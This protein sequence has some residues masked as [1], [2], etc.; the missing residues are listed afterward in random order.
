MNFIAHRGL[1]ARNS[2]ENTLEAILLGDKNPHIKGVE[3]D[4]RLTK[5]NQVVVIHDDII[6]RV[7]DGTGYVKDMSLK[8]LRLY[9]Y[10]TII[11]PATINTLEEVLKKY[12]R[13]SF[14]IIEI[15]D[16]GMRN[17]IISHEV[18]K[19]INKYSYLNIFIQSFSKEI[20]D[21]FKKNSNFKIGALIKKS[22][23]D[24][25]KLDVDFYSI[26]KELITKDL[27]IKL[28][29]NNKMVMIWTI[30][31]VEE[32]NKLYLLLDNYINDVYLITEIILKKDTFND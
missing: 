10:G 15:K 29:N 13:N 19:I 25:L 16:E 30:K 18:L 1:Q 9:N 28:L 11:K 14:L 4:V 24:L 6:D 7:S 32:I 8:R 31:K 17:S 5:D 23:M 22:N 2:C 12:S 21:Y 20:I 26:N 3:I 27:V